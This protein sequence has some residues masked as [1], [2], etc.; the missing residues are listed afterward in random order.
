MWIAVSQSSLW[1]NTPNNSLLS[2]ALMN[3]VGLSTLEHEP[4]RWLIGDGWGRFADDN[5]KYAMV[6]GVHAFK[7]GQQQ[8]NWGLLNSPAFHAHDMAMEELLSLGALGM[9]LWLALPIVALMTMPRAKFWWQ[10]PILT[11]ITMVQAFWFFIPHVMAYQALSWAV[12]ASGWRRQV[13]SAL[14][15]RCLRWLA[16]PCGLLSMGMVCTASAQWQAMEYG[17]R[18]SIAVRQAP[19]GDTSTQWLLGDIARGGDRFSSAAWFYSGW[20]QDRIAEQA[21]TERDVQWYIL[22]MK[23]SHEAAQSP[24]AGARLLLLDLWLHNLTFMLVDNGALSAVRPWAKETMQEAVVMA[25]KA[26]PLRED[27]SAAFLYSI[28]DFTSGDPQRALAVLDKILAVA[29]QHR[30]ALWVK[31]QHLLRDPQTRQEGLSLMRSAIALG[32][33]DVYPVTR[34]QQEAIEKLGN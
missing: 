22:L 28:D 32:V 26:A 13:Q 17:Q 31:G 16:V 4:L 24:A 33:Q 25:S 29:P 30:S 20:I 18:L 3:Q 2:R 6:S 19:A 8:P 34:Q 21:L 9:L 11:G 5:S 10:A 27:M 15:S 1:I 12:L 14:P 7:D 23:A